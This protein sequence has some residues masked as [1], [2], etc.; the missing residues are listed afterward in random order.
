MLITMATSSS[1]LLVAFFG[2]ISIT[3]STRVSAI[4]QRSP[5]LHE[6][7]TT[8]EEDLVVDLP[9]SPPHSFRQYS[10]YVTVNAD[11]GRHLFY[12]FAEAQS[13]PDE[14]PLTLWLNGGPG[15]S[16]IAGGAMSELG[17]FFPNSKGD[18]LIYNKY[19]WT[20][21]S[22]I[23]FL[24]SP[25]GVGFSYSETPSDYT[26]G[27]E[28]TAADARAFLLGWFE[29][30]PQYKNRP[31]YIS[32]ESYAGHY[33]PDLS[34]LLWTKRNDDAG[35]INFKGFLL[36]NPW[37][38]TPSD[39]KGMLDFWWTRTLIST[40]T[41]KEYTSK[42]TVKDYWEEEEGTRCAALTYKAFEEMGDL[43]VYDIYV[44][45]CTA[46]GPAAETKRFLTHKGFNF[47]KMA[48][49]LKRQRQGSSISTNVL[50]ASAYDPCVDSEAETYLN[51][52]DV[53]VALH[54]AKLPYRWI[55]CSDIIDYSTNDVLATKLGKFK[56]LI[57]T[58]LEI[59][60]F[61]GDVDGVCPTMGTR[62]WIE[63]LA[64]QKELTLTKKWHPWYLN[65]QVGGY[66][67]EFNGGR[68][69]F[70]TV[71]NAGHMVPYMQPARG[72]AVFQAF[73]KGASLATASGA[74]VAVTEVGAVV[75]SS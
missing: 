13:S 28:R 75:A 45:V 7:H 69:K 4:N 40:H 21:E 53:Q 51:R 24:E 25:A 63:K 61:S 62:D 60:V 32:G 1:M 44:D 65:Q 58:S 11:H 12:W 20:Q 35:I 46:T 59:T 27:D 39:F 43:N 8:F 55:G 31:F 71:R 54:T 70:V 15:C 37:S 50:S 57:A 9:G 33:I 17:P 64:D 34:Y 42:C 30:F 68:F 49:S 56:A 73:L 14:K 10:G 22:N 18:G 67:E 41:Y 19:A 5:V 29:R 72:L 74:E 38:H 6:V 36:G 47:T 2:F 26:T 48:Q 66:T 23:I 52:P 3:I 16:S